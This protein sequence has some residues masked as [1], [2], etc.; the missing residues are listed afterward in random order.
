MKNQLPA[1]HGLSCDFSEPN[2]PSWVITWGLNI[3]LSHLS[4]FTQ[5]DRR[6][7]SSAFNLGGST[8]CISLM[9]SISRATGHPPG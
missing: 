9:R 8:V 5:M 7:E 6:Y 3:L 4:S 1:Q 2:I